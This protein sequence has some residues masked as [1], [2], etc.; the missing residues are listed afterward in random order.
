MILSISENGCLLRSPES[1]EVGRRVR[2][3]FELPQIG[4]IDVEGEVVYL[5]GRDIGVVFRSFA[6]GAPDAIAAFV[7]KELAP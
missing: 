1:L 5:Q 3:Q 4:S 7:L 6:V 2:L